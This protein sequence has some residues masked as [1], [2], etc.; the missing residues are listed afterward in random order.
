MNDLTKPDGG[1]RQYRT[2]MEKLRQTMSDDELSCGLAYP[3]VNKKGQILAT[4]TNLLFFLERFQIVLCFDEFALKTHILGLPGHQFLDDAA[5]DDLYVGMDFTGLRVTKDYLWSVLKSYSR[6]IR[7]HPVREKLDDLQSKWDGV[8]RLDAWLCDYCGVEDT[9]YSRAVGA[10]W[11]IAGVRR[12]RQ[13]GC[14]FDHVLIFEGDQGIGKSTVFRELAYGRWFTDN[15]TIGLDAKEVI[16]LTVAMWIAEL[17]ELT[18][19]SKRDVESAKHFVTRQED[20]AR[21]AF[22]REPLKVPRQFVLAA[23]T[24]RARYLRDESGDRRFWMVATKGVVDVGN[25]LP[26]MLDIEGLKSVRDQLWAEAAVRE[27]EGEATYLSPEIEALARI[28]QAKRFDADERQQL[29]EDLLEGKTGFVPNDDL[30]KAIGVTGTKDKH[31]GI[32]KIVTAA[33]TRLGWTQHKMRVGKPSKQVRGW[34]SPGA[35]EQV[36][37]YSFMDGFIIV[38]RDAYTT[39]GDA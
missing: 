36:L 28:E 39:F 26:L 18:N 10:K 38:E 8:K 20:E 23:T 17:A 1:E 34:Q 30:Y 22:G 16:E 3:D 7:S 19:I 31:P 33:M 14:K 2:L 24:N 12:I 29:L 9:P 11:M 21:M 32:S 27:A 15:L 25:G 13:P 6:N 4:Q 5:F 37:K 35:D